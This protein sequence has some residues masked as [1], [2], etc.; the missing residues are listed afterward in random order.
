MKNTVV[1]ETLVDVFVGPKNFN[2]TY[3]DYSDGT[4]I[5][6]IEL[7]SEDNRAIFS[8]INYIPL[9]IPESIIK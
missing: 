6:F 2:L 4:N 5:L 8:V 9:I 3:R 7:L 1:Y